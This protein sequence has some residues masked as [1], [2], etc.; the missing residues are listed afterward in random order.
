M[1]TAPPA[2][3]SRRSRSIELHDNSFEHVLAP[4]KSRLQPLLTLS[5]L[6]QIHVLLAMATRSMCLK[7]P[8]SN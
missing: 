3:T 7:L 2:V 6:M 8:N 1:T 4:A 5:D